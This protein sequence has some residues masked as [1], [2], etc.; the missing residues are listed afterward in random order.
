VSTV[1]DEIR[2]LLLR[3]A[4]GLERPDLGVPERV[5]RRARRR[6][7]ATVAGALLVAAGLAAGGY[8]GVNQLASSSL[9]GTTPATTPPQH[10]PVPIS[11]SPSTTPSPIGP[12]ACSGEQLRLSDGTQGAAG[13]VQGSLLF[14]NVASVACTISGRPAVSLVANGTT[15]AVTV[16][17]TDPWWS[18]NHTAKPRGWPVVTVEPGTSAAVRVS[19]NNWCGG[20][21]TP[22]P[23][24]SAVLPGSGST[25]HVAAGLVPPCNGPGQPS[26]L[27]VGPFEPNPPA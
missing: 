8:V 20:A 23:D 22:S 3:R 9:H 11:P 24:W 21:A 12:P 7:A 26:T 18:V 19:W 14:K 17:P 15:L 13:S 4:E 1:E 6:A 5:V 27:E 25:V 16:R 2:E 10:S